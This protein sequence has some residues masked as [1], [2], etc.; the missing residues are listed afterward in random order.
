MAQRISKVVI[1]GRMEGKWPRGRKRIMML[2]DVRE[3]KEE[4]RRR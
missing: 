1:E 4:R 3:E 2:D